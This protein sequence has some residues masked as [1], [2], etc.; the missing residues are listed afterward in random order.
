M[1]TGGR[2]KLDGFSKDSKINPSTEVV[3]QVLEPEPFSDDEATTML[4]SAFE[5]LKPELERLAVQTFIDLMTDHSV[6]AAVRK[7]AADSVMKSLGKDAPVKQAGSTFVFQG[8]GL[9]NALQG[10][11]QM[12]KLTDGKNGS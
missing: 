9:K 12:M 1:S 7:D 11:G 6:P 10:I 8:D 2:M 5:S 4:S 3:F